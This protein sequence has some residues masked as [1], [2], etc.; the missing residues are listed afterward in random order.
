MNNEN[1]MPNEHL[2]TNRRFNL[3]TRVKLFKKNVVEDIGKEVQRYERK[4]VFLIPDQSDEMV[5]FMMAWLPDTMDEYSE[6]VGIMGHPVNSPCRLAL[7]RGPDAQCERHY[8]T[9]MN[10]GVEEVIWRNM[11]DGQSIPVEIL[12]AHEDSEADYARE[13]DGSY[14]KSE[15]EQAQYRPDEN[16]G[17]YKD[18]S[19][20]SKAKY[21]KKDTW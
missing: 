12:G 11:R 19:E 5:R 4:M 8:L 6:V 3:R 2:P 17:S 20:W 1:D 18:K 14:K 9:V 13:S 10:V 15:W 16:A 7:K 21:K